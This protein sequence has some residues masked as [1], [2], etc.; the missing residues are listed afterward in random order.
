MSDEQTHFNRIYDL[1]RG[2]E[3]KFGTLTKDNAH[4]FQ[5]I[6]QAVHDIDLKTEEIRVSL[7]TAGLPGKAPMCITHS[8]ELIAM[9][10]DLKDHSIFRAKLIGWAIGFGAAGGG[11][12]TLAEYIFLT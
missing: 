9:A 1:I 12:I 5:M 8:A 2:V 11:I 3:D 6:T 10:N 4:Q 7:K